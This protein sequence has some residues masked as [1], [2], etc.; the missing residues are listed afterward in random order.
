MRIF[1]GMYL[2]DPTSYFHS[3]KESKESCVE[4]ISGPQHTLVLLADLGSADDPKMTEQ[5]ILRFM[6]QVNQFYQEDSYGKINLKGAIHPEQSADVFGWYHLSLPEKS[7]IEGV[8]RAAIHAADPEVDFKNYSRLIILSDFSLPSEGY[9]TLGKVP[10][11]TQEG[12]VSLSIANVTTTA[13]WIPG[14]I[15]HELGHGFGLGHADFLDCG[16]FSIPRTI[17]ETQSCSLDRYGDLYSVMGSFYAGLVYN[18]ARHKVSLGWLNEPRLLTVTSSGTFSLEPIETNT[19]GLK[20]LKVGDLLI[21]YRQPI[22]NDISLTAYGTWWTNVFDGALIHYA[23]QVPSNASLLIEATPPGNGDTPTLDGG[24]FLV[25]PSTGATL[26]I[27]ENAEDT[28]NPANSR[29]FVK[30]TFP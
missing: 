23:E 12:W 4:D 22:G 10:I 30:V 1:P 15:A 18:N 20:V 6:D 8:T 13:K 26:T 3:K 5:E 25:E 27:L 2:A 28:E 7:P 24:N 21:E 9:G 29:L 16:A 17:T 11:H 14:L 19:E